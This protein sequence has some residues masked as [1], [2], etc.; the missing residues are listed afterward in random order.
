MIDF[1]IDWFMWGW[2]FFFPLDYSNLDAE[3]QAL[4]GAYYFLS[5]IMSVIF[6]ASAFVSEKNE[7]FIDFGQYNWTL[8]TLIIICM[9]FW[10]F[11][12]PITLIGF[13]LF[14]VGKELKVL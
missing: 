7:K 14:N 9:V 4:I 1:F 13:L 3:R 2:N 12:L 5:G 10:W 8:T 11:L 6:I